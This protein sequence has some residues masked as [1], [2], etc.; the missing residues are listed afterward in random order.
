M[1][2]LASSGVTVLDSWWVPQ[3]GTPAKKFKAVRALATLSSMGTGTNKVLATAFGLQS[4]KTS[5]GIVK[6]DDSAVYN[7]IPSYDGSFVIV[8]NAGTNA[9]ADISGDFVFVVTG[10]PSA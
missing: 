10:E 5:A 2:N 7:T 6:S 4:V 8:K 1:A 3:V 9:P